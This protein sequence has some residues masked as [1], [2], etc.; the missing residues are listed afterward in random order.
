MRLALEDV[1]LDQLMRHAQLR[2]R[3]PH[4]VA[5]ARTLHRV[6]FVHARCPALRRRLI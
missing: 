4:F 6:K 3:E 2:K 1:D 5:I